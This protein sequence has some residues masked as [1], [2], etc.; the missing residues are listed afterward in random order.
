MYLLDDHLLTLLKYDFTIY[1]VLWT[2]VRA[3]TIYDLYQR[4]G[5]EQFDSLYFFPITCDTSA[6]RFW[7]IH[8]FY[9][10]SK[11]FFLGTGPLVRENFTYGC[12]MGLDFLLIVFP[13][14]ARPE[15]PCF[16]CSSRAWRWR[17][18][19]EVSCLLAV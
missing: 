14:I 8:F 1:F 10:T 19:L 4:T 9:S 12:L 17:Y 18:S 11:Y 15:L 6:R 13:T 3:G 16:A 7:I 5:I 2:G